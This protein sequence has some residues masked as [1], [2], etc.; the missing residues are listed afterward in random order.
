MSLQT[1][2][3]AGLIAGLTALPITAAA[4]DGSAADSLPVGQTPVGET[5]TAETHGDWEIR[6]IRAEEGQP[7]P[8]QLYQLLRDENGGPVAE[9][10]VFDLPDEGQVV[11]GATVVT[12]LETLLPP[13]IRLR[14]DD[15]EWSEYPFAFCQPIGCFSRLG[16]T[17]ANIDAMRAGAEAF[18]ALVPLPAPDQVIEVSASLTGFTDGFAALQDRNAAAFELFQQLQQGEPSVSE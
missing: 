3:R 11:A 5:Y 9:F 13:G 2:L 18:V 4:Q 1:A 12:P 7:E 6:C 16:L 8:C 17:Q 14:V 10:N 15:G